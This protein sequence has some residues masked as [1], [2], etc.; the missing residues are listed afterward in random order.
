M[1][2]E[3]VPQLGRPVWKGIGGA[4]S[5]EI[6]ARTASDCLYLVAWIG[7]HLRLAAAVSSIH[8]ASRVMSH[9]LPTQSAFHEHTVRS[10]SWI[11][12]PSRPRAHPVQS[13][14]RLPIPILCQISS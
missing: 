1:H 2:F 13:T 4:P 14:S 5:L 3:Q 6:S 11:V 8:L 12:R 10:L 9:C 7:E